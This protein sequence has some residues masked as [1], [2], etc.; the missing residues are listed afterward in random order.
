MFLAA[1]AAPNPPEWPLFVPEA[2]VFPIEAGPREAFPD[3]TSSKPTPTATHF[4]GA[5]RTPR[6]ND[7]AVSII[8]VVID[9]ER[10]GKFEEYRAIRS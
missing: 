5:P 8:P 2:A 3:G 9:Q 10:F 1:I 7:E 4:Q 6:S